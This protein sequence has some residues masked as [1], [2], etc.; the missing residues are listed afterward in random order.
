MKARIIRRILIITTSLLT[1]FLHV[2]FFASFV[3]DIGNLRELGANF[4]PY[5]HCSMPFDVL[6]EPHRLTP[7]QLWSE[8][9]LSA[10]EACGYDRPVF[11]WED[12]NDV[13][14]FEIYLEQADYYHI[15]VDYLSLNT[16]VL[17]NSVT[18]SINDALP[19]QEAINMRLLTAWQ[20]AFR[21][22]VFDSFNNQVLSRQVP[23]YVWQRTFLYENMRLSNQPVRFALLQ[24]WNTITMKKNHGNFLLGDLY[25]SPA[26]EALFMPYEDARAQSNAQATNGH[27]FDMNAVEPLFKSDISLRFDRAASL[28]VSP[29][30]STKRYINIV[31]SA[32]SQPGQ[33]ITYVIDAPEA[34]YYHIALRYRNAHT[35]NISSFRTIR[36]NGE[37]PFEEALGIEFPFSRQWTNQ[38]LGHETPLTFYL[39]EGLNTITL[40]VDGDRVHE[41]YLRINAILE[42]I[43][44]LTLEVNQITGGVFDRNREWDIE[45]FLPH[46]PALLDQW[47]ADFD[48]LILTAESLSSQP[49]RINAHV[50]RLERNRHRLEAMRDDINRLPVHILDLA[51][52]HDS[53][54]RTLSIIGEDF[55]QNPLAIDRVFVFSP[56]VDLPEHRVSL[57]IRIMAWFQR[58]LVIPT[59]DVP[60]G[61][62]LTVWVNR[63]R[64]HV[65]LMQQ[66]ADTQFTPQTGIRVRFS[67]MPNEQKL[68]M[69]N[70]AGTQP[71]VA[72]G[73]SGWLPFELGL[74]GAAV[75]LRQFDGF[76]ETFHQFAPGSILHMV[77]DDRV[78][79]LPETKDF[80][81]TVYRTDIFDLLNI[82]VPDTYDD[83]ITILPILQAQGMNYFLPLSQD[84]ALKPIAA[85]APFVLQHGGRLYQP[86][87]FSTAITEEASIFGLSKMVDLYTIYSL[88]LQVPN[89]YDAFRSGRVPI[90]TTNFDNYIR[91]LFAAP[92]L[93]GRWN[94]ALAPG[95]KNETGQVVRYNPGTAQSVM[96]FQNSDRH[97]D[98][99]AFLEWWLSTDIQADFAFNLQM[100]YGREFIWNSANIEA[101]RTLP[102]DE[103]HIETIIEQWS[104]LYEVPRTPGGY[105]VEREISN[106]WNRVVFDTENVRVAIDD[107]SFIIDRELRRRFREFG[108][109]DEHG[110]IIRPFVL[111]TFEQVS[112][113]HAQGARE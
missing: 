109:L 47:L 36:V 62:E 43:T 79:G 59:E 99:W 26:D 85:T 52:G 78:Y 73:V 84:S 76:Y 94:V 50:R 70:A 5:F 35:Q 57:L 96:M 23:L 29:Y 13:L 1:V 30:S 8:E 93:A 66:M 92:E 15:Q 56:D 64:F 34:G 44:A 67:V 86:N 28:E 41:S 68:V 55:I 39:N 33:S 31:G 69:A 105:I 48:Q 14:V 54:A 49:N 38:T 27:L 95:V 40:S 81:V 90:G 45:R 101:F 37:V 71:H 17:D 11:H 60:D 18:V 25:L 106:I 61:D 4:S 107:S 80:N 7:E 20:D 98:G 42:E 12:A 63:S 113:W 72:L 24:G 51:E 83:I 58:H 87:G 65:D 10:E 104:W 82:D 100:I 2:L 77:Y 110:N 6:D 89:F 91:L 111:P 19:Q 46:A 9:L 88:P 108:Y 21:E 3:I 53:I 112:K 97:D 16:T 75:D 74:R 102:I 103:H 32:F 22:V